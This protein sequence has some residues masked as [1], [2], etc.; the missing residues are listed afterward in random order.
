ML[1][2]G[3]ADPGRPRPGDLP[4]RRQGR[5]AAAPK[6]QAPKAE[7]PKAGPKHAK[8][9]APAQEQ[10]Y[11]V[12]SGDTLYKIAQTHGVDGG[13]Q[14]VYEA[15]REVV[16]DNPNLIFPGQDLSLTEQAATP[17]APKHA[18]P[19][20]AAP[21]HEAPKPAA[22]A[23]QAPAT[24]WTAPV[25]APMGTPYHQA[26]SAWSSGYH[27]GVDFPVATGTGI[28]AVGSGTV[29]SAGWGGAY[30]N[31]VVIRH[32]D[33]KYSQYAHLSSL[34]VTVGETVTGGEQIGLSGTTG[35]SSGPHLH[36]EI[37]SAAGYGSDVDPLAYLRAHG[38]SI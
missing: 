35:N 14:A 38:V 36:F 1:R 9:A 33:G 2:Q 3:R 21:A 17:R 7:A 5:P 18:A 30:G 31:Q 26:G 27:T 13:W 32:E 11:T 22:P 8:P 23:H 16:G 6:A 10:N 37:R 25:D 4:R 15:N 20:P 24:G 34:S 28:K 29:V 19:K 12:V